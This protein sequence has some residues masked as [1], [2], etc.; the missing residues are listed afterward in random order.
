MEY[1]L[2][3]GTI[4]ICP[5]CNNQEWTDESTDCQYFNCWLYVCNSC[6]YIV[7]TKE[8]WGEIGI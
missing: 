5:F 8:Y 7:E 6:G 3:N 2:S 4:A 1:Y